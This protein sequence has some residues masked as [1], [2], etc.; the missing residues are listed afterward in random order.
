MW[1]SQ[2]QE[3]PGAGGAGAAIPPHQLIRSLLQSATATQQARAYAKA[4]IV[5]R[6]GAAPAAHQVQS[7]GK[8]FY[9]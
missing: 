7:T 9:M 4:T 3:T 1:Q 6:L 8:E 2:Y 5:G